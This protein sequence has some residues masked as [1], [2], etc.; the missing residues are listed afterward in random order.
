[1]LGRPREGSLPLLGSAPRTTRSSRIPASQ[2]FNPKGMPPGGVGL[3]RARAVVPTRND[4][5]WP[6]CRTRDRA[7]RGAAPKAA[8][9]ERGVA[10]RRP[11]A[12]PP[13]RD[14][15]GSL[16]SVSKWPQC[17]HV[18]RLWRSIEPPDRSFEER[19]CR[20]FRHLFIGQVEA[21][22]LYRAA[23]IHACRARGGGVLLCQAE[24]PDRRPV[25]EVMVMMRLKPAGRTVFSRV[26][27]L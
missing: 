24:R 1:M 6:C 11:V 26:E 5:S 7:A 3:R 10:G 27:F 2:R 25:A 17:L 18:K 20:S 4:V 23:A 15:Y 14:R 13:P 22:R 9:L 16:Q 19:F 8:A 21:A 12:E